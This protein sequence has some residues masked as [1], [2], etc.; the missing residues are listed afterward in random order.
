MKLVVSANSIKHLNSLLKKNPEAA[1]EALELNKQDAIK[2]YN[3]Y[4][5][6]SEKKDE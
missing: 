2:R 5:K 6:L 4:K 1:K 3:Y